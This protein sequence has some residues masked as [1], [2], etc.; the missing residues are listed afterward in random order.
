MSTRLLAPE[1]EMFPHRYRWTVEECSRLAEEG[2]LTGR[3]EVID[4]EIITKMG[5]KPPHSITIVLLVDWL[6]SLFGA[7]CVRAQI[8]IT[9]ADPLGVYSEPEPDVAVSREPITAY[10]LRH[11]GPEDV[12][13]VVEVADSSIR[14]DLIAKSRLYASAGI[15]EYWVLDV[16]DRLLHVHRMPVDGAYSQITVHTEIESIA[17]A[18]RPEAGIAVADLLPP[19]EPASAGPDTFG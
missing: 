11:P 1:L 4:G 3:Y 12:L 8:P 5:Q 9:L 18:V 17:T 7:R 13:L 14:T 10:R 19:A 16:N 2:R 6:I 15:S